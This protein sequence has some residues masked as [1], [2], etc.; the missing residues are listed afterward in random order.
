MSKDKVMVKITKIG[1]DSKD[2]TINDENKYKL[3]LRAIYCVDTIP[4]TSY[5]RNL[6]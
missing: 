2:R 4:N 5:D 6:Y 3:I 1:Q